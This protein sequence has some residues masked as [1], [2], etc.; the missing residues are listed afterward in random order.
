[1]KREQRPFVLDCSPREKWV[2]YERRK[3]EWVAK[4]GWTDPKVYDE[5]IRQLT[6]ELG[7]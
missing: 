5:F 3:R 6:K 2:E 7:I 1:M 4:H